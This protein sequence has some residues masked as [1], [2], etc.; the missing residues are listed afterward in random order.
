M[1]GA[2]PHP[3]QRRSDMH[4]LARMMHRWQGTAA[5]LWK[6]V[7]EHGIRYGAMQYGAVQY[8]TRF[9]S[10]RKLSPL[11]L[12]LPRERSPLSGFRQVMIS[13]VL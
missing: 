12:S 5:T 3:D 13:R 10:P 7:R 4:R 1:A 2:A 6:N 11:P 9:T 8:V